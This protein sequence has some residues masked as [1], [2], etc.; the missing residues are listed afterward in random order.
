MNFAGPCRGSREEKQINGLHL[1]RKLKEE[2]QQQHLQDRSHHVWNEKQSNS[3]GNY[4]SMPGKI[5]LL[6]AGLMRV[7]K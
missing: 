1:S 2:Q 4:E 6:L 7:R 5:K 3:Q